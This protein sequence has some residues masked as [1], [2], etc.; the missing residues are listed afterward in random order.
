MVLVSPYRR[1]GVSTRVSG[2]L[3]GGGTPRGGRFVREDPPSYT[4]R[5]ARSENM[6]LPALSPRSKAFAF[7]DT[8]I[9]PFF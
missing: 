3:R 9:L 7:A 2:T 1:P 6:K 4:E 5:F 8:N